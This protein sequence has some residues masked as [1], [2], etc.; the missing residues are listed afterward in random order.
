MLITSLTLCFIT[1]TLSSTVS[2]RKCVPGAHYDN[3]VKDTVWVDTTCRLVLN[4]SYWGVQVND[5]VTLHL[6]IDE[7]DAKTAADKECTAGIKELNKL[8][9]MKDQIIVNK[10]YLISGRDSV[11]AAHL[12]QLKDNQG[13]K[14]SYQKSLDDTEK[15]LSYWRTTAI[16]LFLIAV[17]EG[18]VIYYIPKK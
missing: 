4:P 5:Q 2:S 11:I 14:D 8:V 6:C 7:S 16:G 9:A 1:E 15:V 17:A 10:D 12:K 3:V 13:I 18:F